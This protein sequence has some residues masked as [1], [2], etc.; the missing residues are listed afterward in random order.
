M[1]REIKKHKIK[2]NKIFDIII[3]WIFVSGILGIICYLCISC[4]LTELDFYKNGTE[5]TAIVTDCKLKS[6]YDRYRFDSDY[7]DKDNDYYK[8]DII[9]KYNNH[10]YQNSIISNEYLYNNIGI[11]VKKD[12]PTDIVINDFKVPSKIPVILSC[13]FEIII[14]I[15]FL[16]YSIYTLKK[17]KNKEC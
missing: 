3:P 1:K 5:I 8:T 10:L 2:Y 16:I 14:T 6:S 11:L 13:S 4:Y 15:I 12:N 17:R 9:Y 7:T